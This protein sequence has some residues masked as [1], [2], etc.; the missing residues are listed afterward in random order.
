ME[1]TALFI[2]LLFIIMVMWQRPYIDKTS[3]GKVLLWYG[4]RQRKYFVLRE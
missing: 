4:H 3:D 1:L 2:V